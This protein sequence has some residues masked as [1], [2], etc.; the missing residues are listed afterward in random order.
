MSFLILEIFGLMLLA[1]LLGA[2]L[3][4]WWITRRYEDV[5]SSFESL[6]SA[7]G[8]TSTDHLVSK[9]DF[10]A[11]MS[12]MTLAPMEQRMNNI[13]ELITNF[14]IPETDLT[15]LEERMMSVESLLNQPDDRI[16]M[17]GS[18]L[19][20]IEG[21][22]AGVTSSVSGLS[23]TDTTRLEHQLD[24]IAT[25]IAEHGQTDLS[26]IETR[27][28]GIEDTILGIN[29]P[30]PKEVDLGPIHSGLT[31]VEMAV[32]DIKIPEMPEI[33]AVDLTGTEARI[34][35]ISQSV[36]L[37]HNTDVS[38]IERRLDGLEDRL[39]NLHIPVPNLTPIDEGLS[40]IHNRLSGIEASS[41]DVAAR[42][43]DLTVIQQRIEQVR[44]EVARLENVPS[45]LTRLEQIQAELPRLAQLQSEVARLENVPHELTRLE[46]IQAELPR[47]AQLQSEVARLENVPHELTRLE[48][49]QSEIMRLERM[50]GTLAAL[51][52]DVQDSG[53]D[54]T[55]LENKI[56]VMRADINAQFPIDMTPVFNSVDTMERKMD[57]AAMENRLTSIE[58]GLAALHHMLRTRDE[59]FAVIR[60]QE[61]DR[62]FSQAAPP[63]PIFT[64]ESMYR[65][66]YEAAPKMEPP[67]Y[68]I[69][70]PPVPDPRDYQRFDPPQSEP[71]PPK[72]EDAIGDA[73]KPDDRANLL[74]RPAFGAPDDLEDI[75]GVGPMLHGLLTDIGV[76]YFWQIAEWG[77]AE[78]EWVDDMLDGFNGRI[79]RDDWVGQA[80]ELAAREDSAKRP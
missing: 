43:G 30:E 29:I 39:T 17:V 48:Q 31:R 74:V 3:A 37:L 60:K 69:A 54:T 5:T 65:T 52:L 67:A 16:D 51:R 33:P 20:S 45:E 42:L 9:L 24:V 27:L 56:D 28:S 50:E 36:G 57:L 8:G 59:E 41:T 35:A 68:D 11:G 63:P 1:A 7:G 72:V 46:Q 38:H 75:S 79:E 6:T 4:Y 18:R 22:I 23:N 77:P 70:P 64:G 44:S 62:G 55:P 12:K 76:Y 73:R 25:S 47:L 78:V 34:D 71:E 26:P 14:R 58:Y 61:R 21:S 53:T 40:A 15:S 10:E 49:I 32:S 66:D 80:K 19:S 13:E 2:W